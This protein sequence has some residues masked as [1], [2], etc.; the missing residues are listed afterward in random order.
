MAKGPNGIIFTIELIFTY[1]EPREGRIAGL[2]LEEVTQ[3]CASCLCAA[4]S[5]QSVGIFIYTAR[6][7]SYEPQAERFQHTSA[8]CGMSDERDV[9]VSLRPS[10][11]VWGAG[12]Q[13][14]ELISILFCRSEEIWWDG[15]LCHY[16]YRSYFLHLSASLQ[17]SQN[18]WFSE[19]SRRGPCPRAAGV[20][21]VMLV[22]VAV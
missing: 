5:V 12:A 9:S 18:R 4:V 20:C 17:L 3:L 6:I 1:Q 15:N 16:Y 13:A 11:P 8:A 10:V 7:K 2:W 21:A 22:F 14:R 19:N